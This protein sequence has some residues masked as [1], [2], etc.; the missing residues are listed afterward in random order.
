MMSMPE[1]RAA[2]FPRDYEATLAFYRDG[3]E[4]AVIDGWDRGKGDRGTVFEAAAGRIE[5]LELP[6]ETNDDLPWDYRRP[7]GVVMVVEVDD[8]ESVYARVSA[9]G[10]PIAE[11]LKSQSWGHRSFVVTDP[12]GIGIYFFTDER[13][14]S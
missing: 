3:L 10:L 4:L 6:E 2:Y 14:R 7:Q 9:R 12:D 11:E 13:G 5:I 8:V 1:F